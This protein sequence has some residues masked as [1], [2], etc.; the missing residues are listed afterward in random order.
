MVLICYNGPYHHD[1]EIWSFL[2]QTKGQ[3]VELMF[4]IIIY[5]YINVPWN[6]I[7]QH[8]FAMDNYDL[9][10]V[11]FNANKIKLLL[12][13]EIFCSK[14]MINNPF[15]P[16]LEELKLGIVEYLHA[17][18]PDL[19]ECKV[20]LALRKQGHLILWTPPYT[21]EF[22]P[23]ENYWSIGLGPSALYNCIL[24]TMK[25]VVITLCDGWY[26]NAHLFLEH[27]DKVDYTCN[28]LCLEKI[29]VCSGI[30]GTMGNIVEEDNY[31]WNHQGLPINIVILNI[32]NGPVG[33]PLEQVNEFDKEL[34]CFEA[35]TNDKEGSH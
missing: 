14:P 16:S 24:S 2:T 10:Y 34:D 26:G 13:E 25:T 4:Q 31:V 32:T 28:I 6:K 21:P 12:D 8:A 22:Q 35:I 30:N 23:I 15:V 1:K 18:Q 17:N 11:E 9:G 7:S 19:V 27:E 5:L 29:Q 20:E 3:L 33:M